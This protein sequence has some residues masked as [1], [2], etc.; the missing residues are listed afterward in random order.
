MYALSGGVKLKFMYNAV[1]KKSC[2]W[3]SRHRKGEKDIYAL[4]HLQPNLYRKIGL[5]TSEIHNNLKEEYQANSNQV[6]IDTTI[7]TNVSDCRPTI[8]KADLYCCTDL[9]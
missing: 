6:H 4:N 7:E 9:I 2:K 3:N 5:F 8:A 1:D